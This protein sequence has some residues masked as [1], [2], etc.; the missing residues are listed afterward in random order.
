MAL[1]T[2]GDLHLSFTSE[3]PMSVFG[4]KWENHAQKIKDSFSSVKEDDVIVIC[5]DISWAMGTD[6]SI[7]DFKFID[8][9]PGKKIVLKGNHDYWFSTVSKIQSVFS[10]NN[11]SSIE[12]LHNNSFQYKDISLCGTKG[13]FYDMDAK[14]LARETGRLEYSL[15][16]AESENIYV[17]L[18]YP[19]VYREFRCTEI[20]S[21]LKKY[22]VSRCCYGHIH[23]AGLEYV[24]NGSENGTRFSCVSADYLDFKPLCLIDD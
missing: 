20:L 10:E 22:N 4:S 13:F 7:E 2:I 15:Q 17:F 23:S 19:P 6:E 9:L 16:Q 12:I 5:G 24:Y 3:K 1:Y 21:L 14:L 18:H 11:I 8:S